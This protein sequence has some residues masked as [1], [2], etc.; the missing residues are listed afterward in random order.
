MP[1][2]KSNERQNCADILGVCNFTAGGKHIFHINAVMDN[3]YWL[4]LYEKVTLCKG[5]LKCSDDVTSD[6]QGFSMTALF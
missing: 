1:K 2:S 6:L 3:F 5:Q 4:I